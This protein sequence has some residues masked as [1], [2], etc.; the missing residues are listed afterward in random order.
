MSNRL[1]ETHVP[2]RPRTA[3]EI[4]KDWF[5]NVY[6]GENTRQLTFRAVLTGMLLGGIM[7]LSNLYIGLKIGWGL[8]VAITSCILAFAIFKSLQTL[9]PKLLKEE[10]TILENN[11]MQSAASA[12]GYITSAGLT[13]S[14]PAL[15]MITGKTLNGIEL[16]VWIGAIS[17]LGCFMAIPMKRQMINVEQLRFPSG[18]A[19]AET[20]KSMHSHGEEAM[21]KAKSLGL[22][23]LLGLFV[24][25]FRE[26]KVFWMPFNIPATFALPLKIGGI[27]LEKLTISGEGS[28]I[29]VA[30]G[31]IMGTRAA[32]SMLLG[33]VINYVFLAPYLYNHGIIHK[34]GYRGIVGWSMW[35]GTAIMVTSGLLVFF[36]QWKT[37]L[38]AFSGLGDLFRKKKGPRSPIEGVEVPGSWFLGGFI[39]VGGLVVYLQ[40]RLFGISW[41]MGTLAVL[42]TFLLAIVASRASGETDITPTGAMGKITQL[43]YGA[44]AP[45][46]MTANLMTAGVTAGVASHSADLL[47]DL[48]SGYILGANPRYQFIAQ[49]F[50]VLSGAFFAVPVFNLLVPSVDKLGTDALPAPAAQVYAGVARLLSTGLGALPPSAVVALA[51]SGA[52]GIAITLGEIYF[53]RA[54]KYLPSPTG[55]GIALVVPFYNS[56]SMFL[57]AMLALVILRKKPVLSEKYTIPV[58]SGLI[59]GE[60]LMG[61]VIAALA[62]L[63]FIRG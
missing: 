31:A 49:I 7:S 18:T 11:T 33:A 9:F 62:M 4:E 29:M 44:I 3:D 30:A 38:R 48:K 58:S 56:L 59:A 37:V 23:G 39:L 19:A 5:E 32:L 60:S 12:A 16:A 52:L 27:P 36:M 1:E 51:I 54:K 35:P 2:E 22:A 40:Y 17:I 28:L 20:L 24:A 55:L 57:G 34:L 10:F 8:G 21:K 26:G 41:W 42:M 53:P 45:G 25:W 50:G 15:M 61:I 6:A 46:N 43:M 47:Q 14:I 63:G 13:A